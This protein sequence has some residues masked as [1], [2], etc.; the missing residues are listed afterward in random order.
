MWKQ[1]IK[2]SF[3]AQQT[4]AKYLVLS[5]LPVLDQFSWL[6]VHASVDNYAIF[7]SF[8][9]MQVLALELLKMLK[10]CL[11]DYLSH[12]IR[13]AAAINYGV[14]SQTRFRI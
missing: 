9:P 14:I 2:G 13:A 12:P 3:L 6:E 7:N 10:D 8:E 1:A 11:A 4:I 5:V